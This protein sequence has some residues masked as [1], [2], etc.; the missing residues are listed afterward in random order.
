VLSE[1]SY[2]C[3]K[4]GVWGRVAAVST[5]CHSSEAASPKLVLFQSCN[6]E[7]TETLAVCPV[8]IL[9]T[10]SKSMLFCNQQLFL[11]FSLETAFPKTFKKRKK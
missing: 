10:F 1:L 9:I 5:I 8:Q 2:Y 6:R 4:A 3:S 11:A 7:G